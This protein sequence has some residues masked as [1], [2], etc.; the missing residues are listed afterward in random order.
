[1]IIKE[2]EK[3]VQDERA[4]GQLDPFIQNALK[5]HLQIY[6]LYFIFTQF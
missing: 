5:E 4:K 6:V 1:V 2:L 3:I